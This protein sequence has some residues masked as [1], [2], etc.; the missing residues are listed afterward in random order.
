MAQSK[1]GNKDSAYRGDQGS[2][3]IM[4]WKRLA[5]YLRDAEITQGRKC[6]YC[7]KDLSQLPAREVT[8]DHLVPMSVYTGKKDDSHNLVTSC[9]SC[10]SAKSDCELMLFLDT[11]PNVKKGAYKRILASIALPL[12]A[13]FAKSLVK[14]KKLAKQ[15]AKA[16]LSVVA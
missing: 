6:I 12:N 3:W 9:L 1:R 2:K 13:S 4:P 15:S 7:L 8:L 14:E 16:N 11:N 10:N 5:I